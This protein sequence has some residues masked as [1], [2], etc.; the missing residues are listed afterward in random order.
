MDN[1]TAAIIVLYHLFDGLFREATGTEPN[2][3]VCSANKQVDNLVVCMIMTG[4]EATIH[5]KLCPTIPNFTIFGTVF[6]DEACVENLIIMSGGHKKTLYR[7]LHDIF[8]AQGRL[9]EFPVTKKNVNLVISIARD[10]AN[11]TVNA[12][13]WELLAK[14]YLDPFLPCNEFPEYQ[15]LIRSKSVLVYDG[16]PNYWLVNPLVEKL[17]FFQEALRILS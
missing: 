2:W 4:I 1:T 11:R 3:K 7:F 14:V 5:E 8:G 9:E 10:V 16:V 12:K 6:E 13:N 17:S 15:D